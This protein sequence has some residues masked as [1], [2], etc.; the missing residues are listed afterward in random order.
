MKDIENNDLNNLRFHFG[1]YMLHPGKRELLHRD[2][3][4]ELQP[5]VFDL[6]LYLLRHHDRAVDKDELQDAVWSGMVITETALTRAVMKARKAVGDDASRQSI[7]KTLHGHGYRFIAEVETESEVEAEPASEPVAAPVPAK[8]T[9]KKPLPRLAIFAGLAAALLVALLAGYYLRTVPAEAGTTRI[10]V[11]P[12]TDDTGDPELAWTTLGLMSLVSKMLGSEGE[13]ALVA[14]GSVVSL[15]DSFGWSGTLDGAGN[16]ALLGRLQE[17]YGASHVLAMTLEQNGSQ[18]RMNYSLLDPDERVHR[19]TMVGGDGTEL[20]RG[21]V[22]SVYGLL[23][24]RSRA[25][26]GTP[27]ISADPFNNEAYARGMSLSLAGRCKEAV[28]FFQLIVDQEPTLFAP[29]LELA[30]CLR[31]LGRIEE[32]APILLQLVEEQEV[33][34]TSIQLARS[35]MTLGVLYNRSGRLDEAKDMHEQALN[36][37][38]EIDDPE[39]VARVLQNLAIVAEDLNDWEASAEFLDL[40]ILEYQRAGRE[41]LPGQLYSSYANLK[42]DQ[43]ELAQAEDYLAR[44]LAA[45]REVGDRRREA[46]MLNNNGY[47]KRQQGRLDEAEGYHLQSLE[48]RE[49]I[50]DRVGVGRIYGM[51]AVVYLGQGRYPEAVESARSAVGIARETRDRLFE[52]TSLAQLGDAEKAMGEL[53][54][55]RV[56]Y[57]EGRAVFEDIQDRMRVLQESRVLDLIQ[58]EVQAMELLGDAAAA[59]GDSAAAADEY[60]AALERVRESSWTAMENTLMWKLADTHM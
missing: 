45:F 40:A 8:P 2:E 52:G 13:L 47:L 23:L 43:G 42:M 32:A 53:D 60:I 30:S 3:E 17:V 46:M 20:A 41:V 39:L 25:D 50:G 58:P 4:I 21:V 27:L 19:G 38:R 1:E 9:R 57:L 33:L 18:L 56:H 16:E 14:D 59:R 6:L 11:L 37:A 24:G 48:I 15:A 10:A 7:I 29:R 55:A 34:G 51:L 12:L 28:Q 54:S 31:I 26:F 35:M 22:Q 5:R 44:A 36:V 49:E